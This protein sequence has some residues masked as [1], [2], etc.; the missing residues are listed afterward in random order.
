[1]LSQLTHSVGLGHEIM[2]GIE[3]CLQNKTKLFLV[4][5]SMGFGF[6]IFCF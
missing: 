4:S 2:F 3:V 1:M 5:V 6:V